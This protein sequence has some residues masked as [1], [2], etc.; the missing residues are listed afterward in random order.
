LA[1]GSLGAGADDL[2]RRA[3]EAMYRA[4]HAGARGS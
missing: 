4:K 2:I 1:E 3:D